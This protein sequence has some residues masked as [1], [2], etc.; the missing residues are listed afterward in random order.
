MVI[1]GNS[2]GNGRQLA[3]Y[4]LEKKDNSRVWILDIDGV[5]D[6]KAQDLHHA[7]FDMSLTAELTNGTKGLYH[8]QINPDGEASQRMT[9][10]DWQ[11]A[12]DILGKQLGYEGQR[13]AIVMHEKKGRVHAH[14]IWE[15]YDFEKGILKPD[16][17]NF[18]AQDKARH[19]ME[20]L[21]RQKETPKRNKH[22]PE[23]KAALTDLWVKA[24]TGKEFINSANE[25]DYIL[26]AGT[27]RHP[28]MVVDKD[29]RSFDL[30]RQLKGVRIKEVRQKMRGIDLISEKQAIELAKKKGE[31][32]SDTFEMNQKGGRKKNAEQEKAKSNFTVNDNDI[33]EPR[34]KFDPKSYIESKQDMFSAPIK[35]KEEN[36]R[37]QQ[38]QV[39]N[40]KMEGFM[41]N[42]DGLTG[43][44]EKKEKT[45]MKESHSKDSLSERD[46]ALERIKEI[47]RSME[48]GRDKE[49][50]RD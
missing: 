33:S 46:R 26:A 34:K 24:E 50:E 27:P 43:E 22:Q 20:Q 45:E 3:Q 28:F 4:L 1:R 42:K 41:D 5:D 14:V 40:E 29:A 16:S 11:I 30:V 17:F 13:R 49:L 15:R 39:F 6:P 18:V 48:R 37:K 31:K 9:H 47:R 21:F 44:K 12:A 10:H 35:K 25:K 23:M 32:E 8:A 19:E 36:S 2:R 38:Q 7:L